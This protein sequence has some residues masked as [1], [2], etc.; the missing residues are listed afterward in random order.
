MKV[1]DT[2]TGW[3]W[4]WDRPT[5]YG[6]YHI[7][8]L[9]IMVGL[10]VFFC[11]KFAR[12]HDDKIDNRVIFGFG[13]FLVVIETYKQIFVTVDNGQFIWGTFPFQFCSVPM[14]AAFIGPLIRKK[15]I[16]DVFYKFIALFGFVAGTAVMLY[17]DTCFHT[18]YVTILLHTMMWHTS[19]VIMG[20]YLIISKR[21]CSNIKN[22]L[23]EV[24][25][26][27][28]IFAIIVVISLVVNIVSYHLYFGTDK[29]TTGQIINFMY[30]SPYYS[31]P[32]PILGD[33]KEHVHFVFFFIIYLIAFALGISIVWFAIFG[34]RKLVEFIN[35]KVEKKREE[36]LNKTVE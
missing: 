34:I 23:N 19:M 32:F 4:P 33:I 21:Y 25:S 20:I 30:I 8:W 36:K 2:I 13:V 17:P 29:N 35:A 31:C 12:K 3:L 14:Y 24:G 5:N 1:L 7:L 10:C 28:I 6:W 27:A 11:L 18:E 16:Q 22:L 26:G 15:S 9:V